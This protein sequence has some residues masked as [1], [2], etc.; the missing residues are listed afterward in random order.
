MV[1]GGRRIGR[2]RQSIGQVDAGISPRRVDVRGEIEDLRQ[3]DHPVQVDALLLQDVR[4]HRRPGRAVALA[5]EIFRRVPAIVFAQKAL[6]EAGEGVRVL[7]DSPEGLFLVLAVELSEAGAGHVDEHQVAGVEQAVGVVDQL[8]R[9]RRR[10]LVAGSRHMLWPQRT[11]MEP[12]R[13]AARAAVVEERDRTRFRLLALLEIRHIEHPCRRRS[14]LGLLHE[15]GVG[16]GKRL[17]VR[18][19]LRVLLVGRADGDRSRDRLVGNMLTAGVHRSLSGRVGRR[20][21][22]GRRSFRRRNRIIRRQGQRGQKGERCGQDQ[23]TVRARG[24]HDQRR[25]PRAGQRLEHLP[26]RC[27]GRDTLGWPFP[28]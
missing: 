20:G 24:F 23:R 10:M 26:Y 27:K 12:D 14:V 22:G 16:V 6:D 21:C 5:E 1:P 11:H 15:G 19:N 3:Q 17:A 13:R 9:G 7:V 18:A 25:S 28:L 8:V 2:Q 4:Q